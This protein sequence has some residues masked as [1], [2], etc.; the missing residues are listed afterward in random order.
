MSDETRLLGS[1]LEGSAVSIVEKAH[2]LA[3]GRVETIGADFTDWRLHVATLGDLHLTT[4]ERCAP[5]GGPARPIVGG[6]VCP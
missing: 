1:S 2:E 4:A 5:P 3:L 6:N